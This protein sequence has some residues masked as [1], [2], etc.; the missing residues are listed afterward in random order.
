MS[1]LICKELSKRYGKVSA[2]ES[3]GLRLSRDVSLAFWVPTAAVK[4]P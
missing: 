2:L 4:A 1:I 3:V